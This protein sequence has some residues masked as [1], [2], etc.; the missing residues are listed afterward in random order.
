[1]THFEYR[2]VVR[3]SE[4]DEAYVAVVPAIPGAGGDGATMEEA[5]ARAQECARELLDVAKQHG[6]PIPQSDVDE[7]AF[8]GQLRLRMPRSMHRALASAA[9]QEGVS[10]NQYMVTLLSAQMQRPPSGRF[11]LATYSQ[12]YQATTGYAVTAFDQWAGGLGRENAVR[13]RELLSAARD[14]SG[15]VPVTAVTSEPMRFKA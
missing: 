5:T 3:W 8:S 9:E 6:D 13:H 4:P 1:M 7:S 14:V 11:F 10:L 15:G 2:V 12:S